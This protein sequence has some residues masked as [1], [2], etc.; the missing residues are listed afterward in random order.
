MV[1]G[2]TNRN[3]ALKKHLNISARNA[4]K[5]LILNKRSI[6]TKL[7]AHFQMGNPKHQSKKKD[8]RKGFNLKKSNL[9][10]N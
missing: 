1:F 8:N 10:S 3:L 2:N 9:N 4:R 6:N 7:N 5:S